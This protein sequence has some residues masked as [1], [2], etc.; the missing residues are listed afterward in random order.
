MLLTTLEVERCDSLIKNAKVVLFQ[1]EIS[2]ESTLAGL[3]LAKKH[4]G[5]FFR[6]WILVYSLR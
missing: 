2:P 5:K 1:L 4:G 6:A 3:R